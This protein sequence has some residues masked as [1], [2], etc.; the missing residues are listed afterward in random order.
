MAINNF[1]IDGFRSGNYELETTTAKMSLAGVFNDR[2]GS[3]L[4]ELTLFVAH[5]NTI[6][7]IINEV[8]IDCKKVNEWYIDPN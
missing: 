1:K 5:F 7:N 3:Y 4:N 2:G 8:E 6:P